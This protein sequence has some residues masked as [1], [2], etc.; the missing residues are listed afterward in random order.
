MPRNTNRFV[1]YWFDRFLDT[2]MQRPVGPD[3]YRTLGVTDI[4]ALANRDQWISKANL[5][6]KLL[7]LSRLGYPFALVVGS[8][9]KA[10]TPI[11]L[12]KLVR[13]FFTSLALKR[14]EAV[15]VMRHRFFFVLSDLEFLRGLKLVSR[16]YNSPTV[17]TTAGYEHLSKR[18]YK[19]KYDEQKQVLRDEQG[20]HDIDTIVQASM[21]L[22][23]STRHQA[24][25]QNLY[26]ISHKQY[27]IMAMLSRLGKAN[28]VELT[29]AMGMTWDV[30]LTELVR[31]R[32]VDTKFVS[33]FP[34][35][36]PMKDHKLTERLYWLT[37][38]GEQMLIHARN[39]FIK[40]IL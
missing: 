32:F 23:Y 25:F 20:A 24:G 18:I 22:T 3:F 17:A 37:G 39:Y 30:Q 10:P 14:S 15:H 19:Y 1:S 7:L 11:Y 33:E 27:A 26:G 29:K 5:D 12:A 36:V 28:R 2:V 31:K 16:E 38:T 13:V 21:I 8:P 40:Q 9:Q 34:R 6:E 35:D 4:N